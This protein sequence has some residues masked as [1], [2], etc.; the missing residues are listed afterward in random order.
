MK[1]VGLKRQPPIIF[2]WKSELLSDGDD[3]D[4]DDNIYTVSNKKDQ[5][6]FFVISP[7]KLGRFW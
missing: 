1:A 4:N 6:V 5:N 3:D 2:S 7:I